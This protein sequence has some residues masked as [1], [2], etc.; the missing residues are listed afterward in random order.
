MSDLELVDL[1]SY[2]TLEPGTPE[3]EEWKHLLTPAEQAAQSK[4]RERPN[5]ISSHELSLG[6]ETAHI[7][8]RTRRLVEREKE[9]AELVE[10]RALGDWHARQ[11]KVH[12]EAAGWC[13][14]KVGVLRGSGGL[15]HRRLVP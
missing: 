11:A 12:T 3:W 14:S 6:A 13:R 15:R 8:G 7:E 9:G 1:R 2:R 10:I 4:S 5:L